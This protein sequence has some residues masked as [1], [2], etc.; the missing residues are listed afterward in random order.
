[1]MTLEEIGNLQIGDK[2]QLPN[3]TEATVTTVNQSNKLVGLSMVGGSG[4]TT[5]LPGEVPPPNKVDSETTIICDWAD[6]INSTKIPPEVTAT[7]DAPKKETV[8]PIE[9][10]P[11]AS[12]SEASAPSLF[13]PPPKS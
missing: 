5:L 9:I 7:I 1:M 12:P 13:Q 4:S 2:I 11:F 6:L 10:P 3:G 8:A